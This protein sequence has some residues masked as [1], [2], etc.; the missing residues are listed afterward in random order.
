MGKILRHEDRAYWA[1]VAH[2]DDRSLSAEIA[3]NVAVLMGNMKPEQS[4]YEIYDVCKLLSKDAGR[5]RFN[6]LAREPSREEIGDEMAKRYMIRKGP[7]NGKLLLRVRT[8]QGHSGSRKE[9]TERIGQRCMPSPQY[10]LLLMHSTAM[11]N[12]DSI[13]QYGLTPGGMQRRRLDNYFVDTTH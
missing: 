12:V 9:M 4:P 3:F 1:P 5:P 11:A 2:V 8:V 6:L 7:L 13:G 10:P